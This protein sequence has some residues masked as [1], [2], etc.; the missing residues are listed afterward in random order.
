MFGDSGTV[1]DV[2]RLLA[3]QNTP[4]DLYYSLGLES[5]E[6]TLINSL[7]YLMNSPREMLA[8]EGGDGSDVEAGFEDEEIIEGEGRIETRQDNFLIRTEMVPQLEQDSNMKT[9]IGETSSTD[10]GQIAIH[11]EHDEECQCSQQNTQD[12]GLHLLQLPIQAMLHIFSFLDAKD[13]STVGSTCRQCYSLCAD[14]ILWRD[15][16]EK[17]KL[18]WQQVSHRSNPALFEAVN[19]DLTYREIYMRCS[20]KFQQESSG[21]NLLKLPQLLWSFIPHKPPKV[22]MFGPGLE[23]NTSTL[24]R[25]FLGEAS[26][27][28]KVRGVFPAELPGSVGTGF[29]VS[30]NGKVDLKLI[31]LYSGTRQDREN[32]SAA[33]NRAQRNRLLQSV[34]SG[35]VSPSGE[36]GCSDSIDYEPKSTIKELCRNVDAFI[37][38]VDASLQQQ[39]TDAKPEL[40]A[41]MDERWTTSKCPLVILSCVPDSTTSKVPCVTLAK[42]LDLHKLNRTWKMFDVDVNS[43]SGAVEA[44]TW[45]VGSSQGR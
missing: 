37:F 34:P 9:I 33:G 35:S 7:R 20:P 44:I 6:S 21:F 41:L 43:L 26:G 11:E 39:I 8:C 40:F 31:T 27:V 32:T 2:R 23:S 5:L 4:T 13:I 3:K 38:V 18:L 19:S 29:N 30:M 28:F 10:R 17:D 42:Q 22:V 15:F 24:V 12:D 36:E 16:L 45:L 14:Q 25:K 1:A